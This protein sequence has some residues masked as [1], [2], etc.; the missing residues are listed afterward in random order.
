VFVYGPR[1]AGNDHSRKRVEPMRSDKKYTY[2]DDA[3]GNDLLLI[4]R[5]ARVHGEAVRDGGRV[6]HEDYCRKSAGPCQCQ[7]KFLAR[8]GRLFS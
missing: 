8:D 3:A 1:N 7:P 2:R 5:L 6:V 4:R